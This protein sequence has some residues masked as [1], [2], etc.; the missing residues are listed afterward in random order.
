MKILSFF[1]AVTLWLYVVSEGLSKASIDVPIVFKNL[2]DDLC[3]VEYTDHVKISIE[4]PE[5]LLKN[6]H[7]ENIRV[8]VDLSNAKPGSAKVHISEKNVKLPGLFRIQSIQ[9]QYFRV[10]IDKKLKKM[11]FIKTI[12]KGQPSNGFYIKNI[13]LSPDKIQ[14]EGPADVIKEINFVRTAPIDIDGI[15]E[16]EE[17]I[18]A[19]DI[20]S[21]LIEPSTERIIVSIEVGR[22][23][24]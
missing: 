1:M 23:E 14:I 10:K 7:D 6:I 9:P 19:L 22:K 21:G 2:P 13:S 16:D 5:V 12:L 8:L 4:G 11:V 15:S 18:V 3:I 24:E 17:Y 20:K